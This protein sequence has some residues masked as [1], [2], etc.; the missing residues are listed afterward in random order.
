MRGRAILTSLM[1]CWVPST[2][3]A[4]HNAADRPHVAEP[5]WTVTSSA[6]GCAANFEPTSKSLSLRAERSYRRTKEPILWISAQ[7]DRKSAPTDMPL[8][9]LRIAG[10]DLPIGEEEV[11]PS[12][13][14]LSVVSVGVLR[15][16]IE[17][18]LARGGPV[19]LE[20]VIEDEVVG[21]WETE[22]FA[23]DTVLLA[24]CFTRVGERLIT[25]RAPGDDGS[26][27]DRT[28]TPRRSPANWVSSL[29]YPSAALRGELS[30]R[31]AF[32]LVVDRFG[33]PR[34]CTITESSGH[35]VLDD[36]TC[37]TI[38]RRATFYPARDAEGNATT[39]SYAHAVRWKVP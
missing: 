25:E 32:R 16:G 23:D 31:S 39:G 20:F 22:A 12:G 27:G 38:M 10:D 35:K 9:T 13:E 14:S 37:D 34:E 19:T 4:E 33:I 30:G 17:Q 3:L 36:A 26:P 11:L 7:L 21:Q 24:D 6:Y 1:A 8:M 2:V 28:P 29:D 5:G 15:P 18:L